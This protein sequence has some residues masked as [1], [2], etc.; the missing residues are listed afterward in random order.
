M[1]RA[2]TNKLYRTFVKGLITEAGPLTYPEDASIAEDNTIVYRTGN[3]SRRLGIDLEL[4][5]S[6][7][8]ITVPISTFNNNAIGSSRWDAVDNR[9][10]LSFLAL[11]IGLTVRFFDISS[12]DLVIGGEKLFSVDLTPYVV[13]G[14]VNPALYPVSFA[15]GRGFLFIVGEKIEPLL[16][17]Y[18]AALDTISV[19]RIYIQIRDFKGLPD[20]LANDE[21]PSSLS[22]E[23]HYN[24]RNQGWVDPDNSA[25]SATVSYFDQF[26][27][28]GSYTAPASTPITTY[29]TAT[30]RYPSNNKQWWVA[31]DNTGSF[32]PDLLNKFGFGSNRAPRGHYIVDAFNIDRSA[33]SG[34]AGIPIETSRDRPISVAFANGRAFYGVNSNVYFSQ[35]MDDKRKAGFCYQEADPTSED[36]SDLI[37]TDGGVIPI[38]EMSRLV[39]LVPVG[40]GI[41]AFAT[42]GVWFIGG[43]Q[44]GFTALDIS[45]SKISPI[46]TESPD[47]IVEVNGQIYWWSRI[48]IMAMSQKVGVFGPVEGSFD[49]QNISESTIQTFYNDISDDARKYVKAVYDP[50]TNIIQWLYRDETVT[51][52]YGY[53]KILNLDLTL[54][55]FYPWTISYGATLPFISSVFTSPRL[56][57]YSGP[58]QTSVRKTSIKYLTFVPDTPLY[59]VNVAQSKSIDFLDWQTWTEGRGLP[60]Q[61]YLSF[62]ETGYELLDDAMRN[63][64]TPWVFTYFKRTEENY[65]LTDDDD[66]TTDRQSSCQFQVKWAWASSPVSNKYSTKREA[67]R[68]TRQPFFDENDLVFDTG[69]PIVVTRHKVRGSGKA[70]QF[71]FESDEPRKDF[72]LL[73]WAT[74]ITGNTKP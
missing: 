19:S 31:K 38:P 71:R 61:T 6:T 29:H 72:D 20:G 63:K 17:Q 47:S 11:Q 42:N 41:V 55:A 69:F 37:A 73:G 57:G 62:I 16:V 44:S 10:E 35:I 67:Y 54:Q 53:N 23:H 49:N 24:L 51:Q 18:N 40:A 50:Q 2:E 5:G 45:V 12:S 70:I 8:T 15:S 28:I 32:D 13:P 74:N 30:S 64:Q 14:T 27:G 56:A 59:R 34:I 60:D 26:G 9:P 1:A 66:Y 46:G 68:I 4:Y 3:R 43:T 39:K 7:N 58:L 52:T 65:I 33:V 36:I 22:N 25:G 48:G 21:E